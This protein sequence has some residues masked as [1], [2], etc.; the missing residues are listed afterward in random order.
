M[1]ITIHTS[2]PSIYLF[3]FF[4]FPGGGLLHR[5]GIMLL[6]KEVFLVTVQ[7]LNSYPYHFH[8]QIES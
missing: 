5:S 7:L 2:L 8:K 4:R 6:G 3:F 1:I